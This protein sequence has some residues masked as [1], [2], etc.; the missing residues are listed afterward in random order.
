MSDALKKLE[1]AIEKSGVRSKLRR[2]APGRAK[3]VKEAREA[4]KQPLLYRSQG[5]L[6]GRNP[7]RKL[8]FRSEAEY[9]AAHRDIKKASLGRTLRRLD[10]SRPKR[11]RTAFANRRQNPSYTKIP[12]AGPEH[13]VDIPGFHGTP[14]KIQGKHLRPTR[15][16]GKGLPEPT[17]VS[18]ATKPKTA[19]Q[20]GGKTYRSRLRGN[21]GDAE[22]FMRRAREH[23]KRGADDATAS[24][25]TQQEYRAKGYH[26]VRWGDREVVSFDRK[27]ARVHKA[28]RSASMSEF[29][30]VQLSLPGKAPVEKAKA[31]TLY[32][33]RAVKNADEIIAWAQAQGFKSVVDAEDMHVTVC[34]S[35][36]PLNW[37][38]LSDD[39]S[40]EPIKRTAEDDYRAEYAGSVNYSEGGN[41]AKRISGGPREVKA[42]GDKGAVV[43]AF[44]SVS[45]TE[46][47]AQFIRIGATNKFPGYTPHISLT[48]DA[49]GVDIAKVEP[50]TGDILLGEEEWEECD[51]NW[52]AKV[53]ETPVTKSDLDAI[54]ARLDAVEKAQAKPEAA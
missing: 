5:V 1:E 18:F 40:V 42:L 20:F 41:K 24:R 28:R 19:R 49:K 52:Q 21:F 44:Q 46:R 30:R 53:K 11:V 36:T 29:K 7:H 39:W 33:H 48:F 38:K 25:R 47:W 31:K 4:A 34:W 3:R 10:P 14:K 32:V 43:L 37:A 35:K 16:Q 54:A 8:S 13:K 9:E 22:T 26:G 23:M 2:M 45:L 27:R 51:E 12:N 6:D 17:G 15:T 50:F